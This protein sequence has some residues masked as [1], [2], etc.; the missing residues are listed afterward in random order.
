ME[1]I[2]LYFFC[3]ITLVSALGVLLFKNILHAVLSFMIT[4]LGVAVLFLYAGAEF[5]AVSQIMIYAGGILILIVFGLM[6]TSKIGEGQSNTNHANVGIA[7]LIGLSLFGF[8]GYKLL[9]LSV[10]APVFRVQAL[11]QIGLLLLTEHLFAF[12]M[13]TVLLVIALVG[14]AVISKGINDKNGSF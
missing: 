7:A 4:L 6:L 5:L 13:I 3:F 10:P 12:E 14:A 2:L 8:L 1:V 9:G 11:Q